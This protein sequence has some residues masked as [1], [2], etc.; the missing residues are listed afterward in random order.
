MSWAAAIALSGAGL[1]AVG[2]LVCALPGCLRAGLIGQTVGTALLGVGGAAVL[3]GGDPVGAAFRS[4]VAPALGIDRLSGFFLLVLAMAAVPALVFARAYLSSEASGRAIASLTGAFVL[5]LAGLPTARDVS[6]LLA[7][8]EL[9]TLLPAAAIL[10]ARRDAPVRAAVL[11]YL[12]IT[13]IGGAGVWVALL[14]LARHGAIGNP[15]ALAAQGTGVQTLVAASALVGFGTKAG[16][17]PLQS[18]LPQ[19][20]PVAPAHL[21][22]LMSGVMI[23]LA[24]YGL[25]RVEFEW[26][27]ATP[28]W[29]GLTLLA[30]GLVT[31]LGGAL[32]ALVQP[33]LKRV[34]AYSSVENVGIVTLGLGASMLFAEVGAGGW[35]AIAFAA[36]LL[37]IANHSIF[38]TLLFLAAGAFERAVGS[39]ALDGLGGLLRRM[40]WTGTAFLVG[41]MAIAGLPLLNGF[42]SDWLTLQ[43]LLHLAFDEPLGVALAAG[44]ALAGLAATAALSLLCFTQL[45]GLVLLGSP[46]RS[47]VC[48]RG[49]CTTADARGCDGAGRDVRRARGRPGPRAADA[50]GARSRRRR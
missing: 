31:A 18:W 36:A 13:H 15:A 32:W 27:G 4:D 23:K 47:G 3:F 40:P 7:F 42:A 46:R 39:L 45:V 11:T 6:G 24:L 17:V 22:A 9:M 1:V 26:L 2:A 25:I 38:K 14:T 35:A 8:W 10:V 34:L 44:V 29:L 43:S 16:L 33:D 21:S 5:A 48:R 49:R 12:A 30:L 19:A 28:L 50:D 37:H 20:H 41:S